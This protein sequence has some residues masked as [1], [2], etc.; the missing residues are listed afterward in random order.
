MTVLPSFTFILILY[1]P[2]LLFDHGNNAK[3]LD[4]NDFDMKDCAFDEDIEGQT[5]HSSSSIGN[6]PAN[7]DTS[8]HSSSLLDSSTNALTCIFPNLNKDSADYQDAKNIESKIKNHQFYDTNSATLKLPPPGVTLH[9]YLS[10]TK[11]APLDENSDKNQES[12]ETKKFKKQKVRKDLVSRNNDCSICLG[13]IYEGETVSWSA[14][15]CEHAFHQECIMNWLMTLG[16]KSLG[17]TDE[18]ILQL[19]LCR[20]EMK[21]PN[22]RQDFLPSKNAGA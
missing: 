10:S 3:V 12:H 20:F 2:T 22:C 7:V 18:S 16:R 19:R 9:D 15:D 6:D 21:C 4:R 17:T 1:H 5:V 14:L 13:E 8:N 11:L